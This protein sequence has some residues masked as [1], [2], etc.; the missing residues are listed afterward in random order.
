MVTLSLMVKSAL[1]VNVVLFNNF[2]GNFFPLILAIGFISVLQGSDRS[3]GSFGGARVSA[4]YG[5]LYGWPICLLGLLGYS[6]LP[7]LN[8]FVFRKN[9]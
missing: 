3:F 4:Q 7:Y 9:K 8:F 5:V 2:I 1:K 6:V